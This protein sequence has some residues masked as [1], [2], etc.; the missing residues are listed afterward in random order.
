M[1]ILFIG[2]VVGRPGRI[3]IKK[4][5]PELRAEL[6]VDI[7]VANGEN[8][9]GG[10]GATPETLR[11][12]FDGG[13]DAITLGNHTW[14][15]KV[16]VKT[17]DEFDRVVRPINY[18]PGAPGR[19]ELLI[20]LKDGRRLGL[21]NALGRVYMEPLE[22]PFRLVRGAVERLRGKT[23]LILVDMHAEAT[24]EKVAMGWFLDGTCTAVVG[25]HTHV[26]TAD[27][28]VLPKGTAY[29]SDVGMTGPLDSCI[30]VEKELVIEKFLTALPTEFRTA[31]DNP[32]LCGVVIDADDRSGKATKIERVVRK[33]GRH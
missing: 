1:R 28:R 29:I 7:V 19:G 9:A 26:Q 22:D 27:E 24:S 33:L 8:S 18:P 17:I 20:E 10:L 31:R 30:G 23:P 2:D 3:C 12:I 16:L 25:T 4:L 21:V 13:V 11:E 32:A 15:K 6:A 5:V 14:R